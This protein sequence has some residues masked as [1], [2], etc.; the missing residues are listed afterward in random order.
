M[1]S[2]VGKKGAGKTT[3]VVGLV[4]EFARRGVRVGTIKHGHHPVIAD[5]EG[6]DTWRH[7]HEAKA[8]K[9]VLESPGHRALFERTEEEIDPFALAT[10]FFSDVDIVVVEGFKRFAIPKIEIY[11]KGVHDT[12]LF[13]VTQKEPGDWI[14]MVTDDGDLRVPFPCFSFSDTS[15]FMNLAHLAWERA[16]I[17]E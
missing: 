13:D 11:R 15:W 16:L 10:R 3:L 1:I 14:A 5:Q 2:V 4:R 8:V 7:Y 6:K 9:T 17:L 12:P